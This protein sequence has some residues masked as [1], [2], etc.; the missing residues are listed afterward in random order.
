MNK[1]QKFLNKLSA[2]YWLLK[3]EDSERYTNTI[4]SLKEILKEEG[5]R[6]E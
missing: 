6:Y 4:E 1:E 3:I 2:I 5:L